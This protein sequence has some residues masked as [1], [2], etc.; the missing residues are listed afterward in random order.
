M[1][2]VS[3][4]V[5]AL[6]DFV[7][8]GFS[9]QIKIDLLVDVHYGKGISEIFAGIPIREFIFLNLFWIKTLGGV[10]GKP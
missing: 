4:F 10:L 9:K 5:F 1:I 6:L 3:K 2:L 8:G 7:L